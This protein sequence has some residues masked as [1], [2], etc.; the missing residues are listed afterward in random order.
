[1]DVEVADG[2]IVY[3]DM[4]V[5]VVPNGL[6]TDGETLYNVNNTLE[7]FFKSATNQPGTPVRM[8]RLYSA[9][10]STTGVEH[11][12][13]KRIVATYWKTEIIGTFDGNSLNYIYTSQHPIRPG[14]VTITVGQLI[15]NDDGH[16]RLIGDVDPTAINIVDYGSS[17]IRFTLSRNVGIGEEIVLK[18]RYPLQYQRSEVGITTPD[19]YKKTFVGKL[20][21]APLVK[22]T[23]AITDGTQT[24][25]DNGT[26]RLVGDVDTS[27][28]AVVDYTSGSYQFTFPSAPGADLTISA[29]YVQRLDITSGDIPIEKHQLAVKG[30]FN[31]GLI[32]K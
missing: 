13:I 32:Q 26:G 9:I 17:S 30:V 24:V 25:I 19:G 14:T 28:P 22:N 10:Q 1:V 6:L 15:I 4:D 2:D 11:S 23:V 3:I 29:S 12:L 5:D 7:E 20:S 8:S 27:K 21:F 31:I 16:G 18:Y